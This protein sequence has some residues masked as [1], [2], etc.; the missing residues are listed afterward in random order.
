MGESLGLCSWNRG[1]SGY[2]GC[3]DRG[4][5]GGRFGWCAGSSPA[6]GAFHEGGAP[7]FGRAGI[8]PI[9]DRFDGLADGGGGVLLFEAV[10][11]EVAFDHGFADGGAVVD[12]GKAPVAGPRVV[13]ARGGEIG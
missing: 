4:A 10:A 1:F 6:T 12:V 7:V 13:V 2:R 9:L 8:D 11:A 5:C 3:R